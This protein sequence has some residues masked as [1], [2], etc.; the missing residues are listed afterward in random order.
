[1]NSTINVKLPRLVKT[2]SA[3]L[4][5]VI[6]PTVT[7][8]KISLQR[9]TVENIARPFL[10][11]VQHTH[12]NVMLHTL[13]S[14]IMA[15]LPVLCFLGLLGIVSLGSSAEIDL[16]V[17]FE[18]PYLQQTVS[19]EV[20]RF[21][22]K[23]KNLAAIIVDWCIQKGAIPKCRS[24]FEAAVREQYRHHPSL[25]AYD[26]LLSYKQFSTLFT[27]VRVRVSSSG[28]GRSVAFSEELLS[29]HGGHH[30]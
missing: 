21:D 28:G 19:Q 3:A 8:M 14:I 23:D 1:M 15:Q 6:P 22:A 12:T 16:L 11:I 17:E 27:Q 24:I 10:K 9:T 25:Q 2:L 7:L 20:I 26:V 4:F 29:L 30:E 13:F 5:A 18:G